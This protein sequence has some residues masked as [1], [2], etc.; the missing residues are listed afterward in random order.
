MEDLENDLDDLDKDLDD[1]DK[2]WMTCT[3]IEGSGKGSG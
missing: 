2:V 3:K 1:L